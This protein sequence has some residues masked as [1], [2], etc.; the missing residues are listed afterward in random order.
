MK[1]QTAASAV[2]MS[3][4]MQELIRQDKKKEPRSEPYLLP[5]KK[6]TSRQLQELE[7]AA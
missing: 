5:A 3:I 7:V 2:T 6:E 4:L 1:N